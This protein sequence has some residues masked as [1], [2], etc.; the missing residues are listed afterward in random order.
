M[1]TFFQ[2]N[3]AGN[4]VFGFQ[5]ELVGE[6]PAGDSVGLI[7]DNVSLDVTAVPEP[8]SWAMMIVGFGLVGAVSRRRQAKR[9]A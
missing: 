8:A 4:A 2:V 1:V 7:L 3:N 6:P 9:F 5:P